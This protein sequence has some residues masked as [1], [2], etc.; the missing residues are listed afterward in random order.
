MSPASLRLCFPL[1]VSAGALEPK[2]ASPLGLETRHVPGKG[3]VCSWVPCEGLPA[4]SWG[5]QVPGLC[6]DMYW[7]CTWPMLPA[8]LQPAPPSYPEG[9][10]PP[11]FVLC[12]LALLSLGLQERTWPHFHKQFSA[13]AFSY[14]SALVSHSDFH[15]RINPTRSG[16]YSRAWRQHL[17]WGLSVLP[18]VLSH[19]KLWSLKRLRMHLR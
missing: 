15:S 2:P 7:P 11:L 17:Y 4:V 8:C 18:P 6:W 19:P 16:I 5:C 13:G 9:N 14:L 1:P 10:L 3:Y 12:A